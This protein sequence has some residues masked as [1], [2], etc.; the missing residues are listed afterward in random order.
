MLRSQ[1]SL[2]RL[3]L[4]IAVCTAIVVTQAQ[5]ASPS[6]ANPN[7]NATARAI[8]NYAY[9]LTSRTDNR[10]ISGQFGSYGD[11]TTYNTA[12]QQMQAVY[13]LTGQWPAITG[14]DCA[15]PAGLG[16]VVRYLTDMWN[17]GNLVTMSCHFRNPWTGGSSTDWAN[18]DTA[19]QWDRR[20]VLAL[21]T[22][23]SSAYT[24][25]IGMLDNIAANLQILEDRGVVVMWR[26]LHELNGTWFW[27][28]GQSPADF[29]ALWRH[30]FDY[31]TRVKGLDNLLWVYSPNT[32]MNATANYPGND[33]VDMVGLD[34]YSGVT[35]N[36]LQ[37][38]SAGEY[39]QLVA[40]GKPIGLFE[41]GPI[42]ATGAGW[43]TTTYNWGNLIRD[44]KASYPRIFL[45][46]AWEYVWQMGY[47]R[48]QGQSTFM[49][50]S[51]VIT[52]GDLPRWSSVPTTA[53]VT[54]TT[55]A[56]TTVRT[57]T[58]TR[59]ATTLAPT[60]THPAATQAP[61]AAPGTRVTSGIQALYTFN[62]GT[63]STVRDT[64][65]AGTA[66]N[67]NISY[68]ANTRWLP[69]GGLELFRD[70][71]ITSGS[72]PARLY[73]SLMQ[74]DAV[75]LEAWV[76]PANTTM[77]GARIFSM[78][79]D[80]ARRNLSL[81][82]FGT[83]YEGR[84]RTSTGTDG[85]GTQFM[86]PTNTAAASLQ[87]I[88]ITHS[89]DGLTNL[90]VN[91]VVQSTATLAGTLDN[92]NTVLYL[93]I[94]N[95]LGGGAAW[96]GEVHLVALYNRAL[97]Q[98]EVAQN[99]A[100]GIHGQAVTGPTPPTAVPTNTP[101][102]QP[103]T[104]IP[105]NTP[106]LIPTTVV[107]TNTP[108]RIPT[109][110]VPTS[111]P[112]LVPPTTTPQVGALL[113]SDSPS[114][115]RSVGWVS[116]SAANASG[117]SYIINTRANDNLTTTF[118][119]VGVEIV[120]V[121]GSFGTFNI[122]IDGQMVRTV[123][124]T[125]ADG[126]VYFNVRARID[127]L[128]NAPHTL[129]ILP[130]SSAVAIDAI[131]PLV[132]SGGTA[133]QPLVAGSENQPQ[134]RALAAQ[135]V[136]VLP[137]ADASLPVAVAAPL[138]L[139][140]GSYESDHASI[141]KTAGWSLMTSG[142]F[143]GGTALM[144]SSTD[145]SLTVVF[146]GSAISVVYAG[147]SGTGELA[148][149]IDGQIVQQVNTNGTADAFG[150]ALSVDGLTPSIH[151]LRVLPVNSARILIDSFVIGASVQQPAPVVT[152]SLPVDPEAIVPTVE[153]PLAP[154]E[155]VV[156]AAPIA[157]VTS[158]AL[159]ADNM[160]AGTTNWMTAG[161]WQLVHDDGNAAVGYFW[162]TITPDNSSD[163][164]TWLIPF[165]FAAASRPTLT[166]QSWLQAPNSLG[167]IEAS[168]DGVN[169]QQITT[170]TPSDAWTTVGIDLS[171]FAGQPRVNVRFLWQQ[172]T[173]DA[174]AV[175]R[176]HIDDVALNAQ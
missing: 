151:T 3:A 68:P 52:R 145:D 19:D 164:L 93:N 91:G 140:A 62:E 22:P 12:L 82:Q 147:N 175:N 5:N 73:S 61:V 133:A 112:T 95:E 102:R 159:G 137:T 138:S 85:N 64:S 106:T 63:G 25:W 94:G 114:V 110:A 65:G 79:N 37:I 57:N 28:G 1:V 172:G 26:P 160:E 117:S 115:M 8:L 120:Y 42:P 168:V 9:G 169:W 60:N 44:I 24:N 13:N 109:T 17:A 128:A 67:L 142:S 90:Y 14:M 15:T 149:E 113:E 107:P 166:F 163:T 118:A 155:P 88:V 41:F 38:N 29:T 69:G 71:N 16:E 121:S 148:L 161:G 152:T 54:A 78:S 104:A 97:T 87:H 130:A 59:I 35:E 6:P 122:E 80:T 108:T 167:W 83:Q 81:A 86:A 53:P 89:A 96:F 101:I 105:T 75:T 143:S 27:W 33:V 84:M 70:V 74:S 158:G 18:R 125:A 124:T 32:G 77:N 43:D 134:E 39:D 176:W 7:A 2:L 126:E 100:A 153:P 45:V 131:V 173:T 30:M 171:A 23:G 129:R 40:T 165:D 11:G 10:V 50:D 170:V 119:G 51:W 139:T 174:G 156:P 36:P 150:L 56:P 72:A 116:V 34:E 49:N 157:P 98:V 4:L 135:S 47:S 162:Q 46:Q 55:L 103:T 76:K 21:T 123:T 48:Y 127:G 146:E 136:E 144:S 111:L 31:F 92:W 66:I 132:L 141:I 154:A 58:P 20:S 99:L